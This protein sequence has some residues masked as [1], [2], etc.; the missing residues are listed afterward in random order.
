MTKKYVRPFTP[1]WRWFFA[2]SSVGAFVGG[3]TVLAH[4]P[5]PYQTVSASVDTPV[6]Q[7]Q[8][9]IPDTNQNPFQNSLPNTRQRQF[10]NLPVQGFGDSQNTS[11]QVLPNF[12]TQRPTTRIGRQPRLRS[13]GS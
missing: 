9:S 6:L 3:W 11:P 13:G 5:N 7:A 2:L 4:T 8:P 10:Q 1:A 12:Q